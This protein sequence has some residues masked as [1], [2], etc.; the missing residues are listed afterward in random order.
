[1]VRALMNYTFIH[2]Y[3][4]FI[5]RV[6]RALSFSRPSALGPEACAPRPLP[7][8]GKYRQGISKFVSF[9]TGRKFPLAAIGETSIKLRN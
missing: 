4:F 5:Y 2:S 1:M 9:L 7:A 8:Q 6:V 3:S